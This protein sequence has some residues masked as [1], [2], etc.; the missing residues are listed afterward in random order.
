MDSLTTILDRLS[1]S[2][3][4]GY[5]PK[6]PATT[7]PT[8]LAAMAL[9]AHGRDRAAEPLVQRLVEMQNKNGSIGIDRLHPEPCWPT[10]WA[11]LAWLAAQN[12]SIHAPEYVRANWRARSWIV[13]TQGDFEQ[14]IDAVGHDTSMRGW[15]WV[16]GT[17]CWVEP[18]AFNLLA[19]KRCGQDKHHR[20][21]E[22]VNLLLNRLLDEGG[23]NYGNTVVFGQ[24][25]RPHLE[26]TGVALLALQGESDPSG[27]LD[28]TIA[29]LQR[30]LSAETTTA[31]LCYGLLGLAAQNAF[32]ADA[33]QWL[34]A[35]A[36]RTLRREPSAYKLA[37]LALAA[38]GP[39][40][41]LVSDAWNTMPPELAQEMQP[42]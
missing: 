4:C 15:P 37:L 9:I 1:A 35:T 32:P 5:Q 23:C 8:A 29:F 39:D 7:E 11:A 19:L 10:G 2:D 41:P 25:L 31:S 14:P 30:E 40:C 27:R 28:R 6:A 13:S 22:A 3:L 38:L 34:D 33:Q 36:H 18:T 12:C 26:P 42:S 16:M 17:H 24:T 20:A 21:R